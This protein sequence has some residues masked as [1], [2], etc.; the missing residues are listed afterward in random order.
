[1]IYEISSQM[2]N[3]AIHGGVL[4][5]GNMKITADKRLFWF[6][7]DGV[8]FDMSDR[9]HRDIYIQQVLSKGKSSDVKRLFAIVKKPDFMDSLNRIKRFLPKEVRGFW[10]DALGNTNT[11]S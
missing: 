4:H 1:M 3:S 8:E 6:L 9:E 11:P 7:R 5:E 2:K 10:E